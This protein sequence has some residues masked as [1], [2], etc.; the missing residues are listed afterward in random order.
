MPQIDFF[1]S[2]E[3]ERWLVDSCLRQGLQ[4]IP[5]LTYS[6]RDYEVL[7][8]TGE[9]LRARD[10]ARLFFL[11]LPG[12]SQQLE[13]REHDSGPKAGQFFIMQRNGGPVIDLFF[14]TYSRTDVGDQIAAGFL[15]YHKTYWDLR[16]HE[17]RATP[18]AL[19]AAYKDLSRRIR[20]AARRIVGKERTYFLFPSVDARLEKGLRLV[21]VELE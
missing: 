19:I 21:G 16:A 3:D 11:S 10:K 17:N 2:Q 8:S 20:A 13:M 6:S 9:V 7:D 15:G 5:S 18:E 1:L 14:P 4:L 12:V